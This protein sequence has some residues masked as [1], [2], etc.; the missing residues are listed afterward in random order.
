MHQRAR[1]CHHRGVTDSPA[2]ARTRRAVEAHLLAFN[3][4]DTA[5][6]LDGV[7]PAI[8]WSTGRDVIRGRE[9]LLDIFDD[10]LWGLRP[11]LEVIHLIVE[12]SLAAAECVEHVAVEGRNAAFPIVVIFTVHDDLLTTVKVFREGTAEVESDR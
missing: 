2:S 11:R 8:V 5:A 3:T 12:E 9:Q 4:H 1:A 10:W 6:I 7:D